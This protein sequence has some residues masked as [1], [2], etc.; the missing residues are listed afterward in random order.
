VFESG[1][2]Q[3]QGW[4]RLGEEGGAEGETLA[5]F[6]KAGPDEDDALAESLEVITGNWWGQGELKRLGEEE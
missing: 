5:F 2:G 4:G 6:P 1:S 3:H